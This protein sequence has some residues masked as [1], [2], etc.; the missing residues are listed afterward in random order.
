MSQTVPTTASPQL[1]LDALPIALTYDG[2][3][4]HTM[5]VVCYGVTYVKTFDND[6][7]N[8]TNISA[9]VAQ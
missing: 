5:T 7:T 1:P 8:I 9:W 4:V 3:F 6:G 2:D